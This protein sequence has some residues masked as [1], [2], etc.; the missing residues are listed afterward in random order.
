MIINH[1]HREYQRRWKVAG[2]NKFNGAF[3]Y[4]REICKNII[5]N[6]NTD[7]NWI[8]VN[9][10]GVGADHSIVFV[11]NNLRPENYEWL[12]QYND[13]VLVCGV[14]E[15]VDKVS[16]IGQAIYLPLSIDLEYV[17]RFK[18]APDRR[19]GTAFAGRPSKRTMD[20]ANVPSG[21]DILEGMSRPN[22]LAAMATRE[23]VY[24]VGRT[25]IEARALGCEVLPYDERFPDPDR[26]AVIDNKDAAR[27]LQLK[28]DAIDHPEQCEFVEEPIEEP[29]MDWTRAELV[30]YAEEHGVELKSKDT[31]TT[32]L[33]RIEEANE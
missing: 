19:R 4:S 14:P 27:I 9:L 24:A 2:K 31:K 10:R 29:N 16:H 21:V 11:H 12:R 32:I 25:A 1:E 5:P 18:V 28:L 33:R 30:K 20:S 17:E 8:T 23:K 26:W 13:I 7:R 6:V 22:L 3:Y 15:T